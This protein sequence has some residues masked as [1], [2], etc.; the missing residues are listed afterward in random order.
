MVQGFIRLM[1]SDDELTG[2][3]NLGNPR[4]TTIRELAEMVIAA[5][6]SRSTIIRKPLPDDDPVQ[7]QPNITLAQRKLGWQPTMSLENG[8]ART[9]AYFDELLSRSWAGAADRA[10]AP[11]QRFLQA[12]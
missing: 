5:V 2:P 1:E 8:L 7:R 12:K 9:I 3:I 4:E 11:Q 6:G 10:V